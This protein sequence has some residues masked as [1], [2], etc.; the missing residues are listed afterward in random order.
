MRLRQAAVKSV[1][2]SGTAKF[3]H[4]QAGE[5]ASSAAGQGLAD[6]ARY[7][8]HVSSW[9]M[10]TSGTGFFYDAIT[11]DRRE[12]AAEMRL[13]AAIDMQVRQMFTHGSPP[14]P[15]APVAFAKL[16]VT[17][18][19]AASMA[20]AATR[21]CGA[22]R[23]QRD[24]DTRRPPLCMRRAVAPPTWGALRSIRTEG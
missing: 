22:S 1:A 21:P 4:V 5:A 8:R 14:A 2:I 20:G 9:N 12:A 16:A 11:S 18:K 3:D 23:R 7:R 15:A 24:G 13:C 6:G 17:S 19:A 10:T